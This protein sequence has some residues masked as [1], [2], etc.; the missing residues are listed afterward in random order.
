MWCRARSRSASRDGVAVLTG[1]NRGGKTVYLQG[2]GLAQVLFQA[3]LFC[4]ARDAEMSPASG[5][6]THYQAEE[7]PQQQS[8]RFGEE[9]ARLREILMLLTPS[10]ILLSNE[11][12]TSTGPGEA[13]YLMLDIVRVLVAL[14]CRSL[15]ATHL[16]EMAAWVEEEQVPGSVPTW[17]RRPARCPPTARLAWC[18]P[19]A[20]SG[21]RRAGHSHARTVARD[22]GLLFEQIVD[23]LRERGQLDGPVE[24]PG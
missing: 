3:G 8:G 10:A 15:L 2:V 9:A 20:S 1:P 24:P 5:L 12:F 6:Y 18:R 23:S 4:P 22:N 11:T 17:P 16:H 7:K 21:R 13:A 14:G 19:S